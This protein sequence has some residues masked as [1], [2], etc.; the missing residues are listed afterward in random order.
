[1]QFDGTLD[2]EQFVSAANKLISISNLV[3]DNW[4]PKQLSVWDFF[5]FKNF[6]SIQMFNNIEWFASN[7]ISIAIYW[8]LWEKHTIHKWNTFVKH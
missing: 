6:F 1:M 4:T 8:E 5:L 2:W 7:H 3:N